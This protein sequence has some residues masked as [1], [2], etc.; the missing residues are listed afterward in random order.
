MRP[1]KPHQPAPAPL[2]FTRAD[3]LALRGFDPSTKTCTMNCGPHRDDP[4]T[5]AERKFLCPECLPT[6]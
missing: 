4:R 5:Q 3:P 6:R 2:I 1:H